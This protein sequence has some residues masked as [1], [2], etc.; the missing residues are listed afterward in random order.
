MEKYRVRLKTGRVVGPF[1]SQQILEMKD[2][3]HIN[4]EEECQL[5][6][7]GDWLTLKT[8]EFW[9]ESAQAAAVGEGTFVLDLDV[10]KKDQPHSPEVESIQESPEE[11][12]EIQVTKP[13]SFEPTVSEEEKKNFREFDYRQSQLEKSK[14]IVVK[15]EDIQ[16]DIG[17]E[18]EVS[19]K[20][21]ID[22]DVSEKTVVRSMPTKSKKVAPVADNADKTVVTPDAKKWKKELEEEKRRKEEIRLKLEEESKIRKAEAEKNKVDFNADA[23]QAISLTEIRNKVEL[24]AKRTE[25]E[26]L[27]QEELLDE[28]KRKKEKKIKMEEAAKIAAEAAI[29]KKENNQAKRKKLILIVILL[30]VM[31][32]VLF[33]EEDKKPKQEFKIVPIDPVI[34]FPVPFDVKD[35][36]K[37]NELY[38]KS[39][40]ML[41]KGTY[42]EK[43]DAAILARQAYEND[44]TKKEALSRIVRLYGEL[45]PHSSAFE[46]DGN[47]VFKLLQANRIL[48]DIDPDVALGASLFYR[49]I[50]KIDAGHE[51]LDRFV[52]AGSNNPTKE[53]FAT[54]LIGLSEK[55]LEKKADDVAASLLKIDKR[56]IEVTDALVS[57][58]RYKNYPDKAREALDF[59]LKENPTSVPLLI[60]KGEFQV[61]ALDMKGLVETSKK[62]TEQLAE[63]SKLY[64]GK[65]LEFQGF[66]LAFQN[67][68]GEAAKKFTEALKFNDSESLRDKLTNIKNID[69]TASDEASKLIKQVQ[70]RELSKE[71]ALD[72]E[73]FDFES[74]LLKSLKATNLS[75][76][77]IKADLMLAEI[78][79][80]LGMTKEAIETLEKIQ[81]ENATDKAANFALVAAYIDTYKF[82]DAKRMFAIMAA[83]EMR[84]DWRYSSLN[85][86]MYEKLGDLNQSILWLQKAINQNPLED[87]NLYKLSKLFTRAK[88]FDQAK[89]NLFK[90]MELNP[91]YIEYKLAYAEIIYEIDGADKAVDY[92]FGLLKQFP[93]NPSILGDIAIYYHK[94]GKNQQFLDTKKDIEALPVKDPRVYRFLIRSSMLDEKIE[95]AIKYTEELVKLEPGDLNSMME[96]G[97][98]LMKLKRYQ[99]AAGWFVK[100]RAKLPTYPRVGYYKAKIELYVNNKEQA[101]V[102]V[103]EDMKMNGEYEEGLNLV[104]DIL[105][106]TDQ[107][108]PSEAEYKKALRINT[109]SYGALRGLADIAFKRGNLDIA[110]DLYKRAVSDLKSSEEPQIHRKLGDVY[111]LMGQ[112]SL[113]IESYNVYLKLVPDAPEKSEIEQHIRVME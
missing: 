97:K 93:D 51:V 5:F 86:E 98:M 75:S 83:S 64:Y 7:T 59:G 88:R 73:K 79:M 108:V 3:E 77:Y 12:K 78:Q 55:N 60:H 113:A 40:E 84:E 8:F 61:E 10:L 69:P 68:T 91:R 49:S 18:K 96:T 112:G 35:P 58:F 109:R 47:T 71:A 23:T 67:K 56:G 103:K 39:K 25:V 14:S 20:E 81:K 100:V 70:A 33:P 38:A 101:L 21:S 95:D 34:D 46:K 43:I 44:T 52:N 28:E 24:E 9:N 82:N 57:Y 74:A 90:A 6:P 19:L 31:A 13:E 76:G 53:L 107:Y 65:L 45:L 85:A 72:M 102:D 89:N 36:A 26:I 54:Y 50:S 37:S 41:S 27:E 80:R 22:E 66:I 42:P 106:M 62:I 110:L 92:L 94:A 99:E 104:G 17:P 111:R 1:L 2:K 105:F 48:Q 15:T 11:V 32:A 30:G 29:E 87:K 63:K 16:L 4:G